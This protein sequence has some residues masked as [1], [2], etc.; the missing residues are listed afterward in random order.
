MRRDVMIRAHRDKTVT[1]L[2]KDEFINNEWQIGRRSEVEGRLVS[3]SRPSL[4]PTL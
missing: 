4:F 1:L 3:W 2:G